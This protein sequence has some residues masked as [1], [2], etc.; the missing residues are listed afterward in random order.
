MLG[1]LAWAW[2][3]TLAG[4]ARV[5]TLGQVEVLIAF[6]AGA[7]MHAERHRRH[8]YAAAALVLTGVVLVAAAG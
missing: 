6:A 2:G 1:S 7:V 8:E 4:A 3:F 5:R